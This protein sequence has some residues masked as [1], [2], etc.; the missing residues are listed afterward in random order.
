MSFLFWKLLHIAS[1]VIFLGNIT[2]GLFWARHAH[3][4][5]DFSLVAA[6]FEGIVRSDRL[7]T[8][9]GVIGIVISG[10]ATA[11]GQHVPILSTG[12]VLWGIVLFSISGIVFGMRVAPLQRKIVDL[13]RKADSNQQDWD[14]YVQIFKKWELWG[15]VALIMPVIAMVIMVLKPALPGL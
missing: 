1:V 12:W 3:K 10:V 15:L 4:S 13:A 7:M 9:P 2:T 6:T 14:T 8:I 11:I 5:R